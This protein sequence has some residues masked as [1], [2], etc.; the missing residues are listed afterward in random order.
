[1]IKKVS[2]ISATVL[3]AVSMTVGSMGSVIAGPHHHHRHHGGHGGAAFVGGLALGILAT[4]AARS[5]RRDGCY[6]G[7][8]ECHW[9]PGSCWRDD[10]GARVCRPGHRECSRRVYCD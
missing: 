1:M 7:P 9:V 10:D 2:A 4:E 3:L 6:R 5:E 8:K